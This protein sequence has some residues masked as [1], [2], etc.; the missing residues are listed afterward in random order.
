MFARQADSISKIFP[1]LPTFW[2]ISASIAHT[3][4]S[5]PLQLFHQSSV[6]SF[7]NDL[8][9]K[10]AK[11][12]HPMNFSLSAFARVALVRYW[13]L[14]GDYKSALTLAMSPVPSTEQSLLELF[15]SQKLSSSDSVS[16]ANVHA[17]LCYHAGFSALM[18][19]QFSDA[20]RL[21]SYP[22]SQRARRQSSRSLD[23][24]LSLCT[25]VAS[26]ASAALSLL[27]DSDLRLD[28]AINDAIKADYSAEYERMCKGSV[29]ACLS[30]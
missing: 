14:I 15:G 2:S 18:L 30:Q 21:C 16:L 26:I 20:A 27:S 24:L 4:C 17:S 1:T 13:T 6:Q 3:H 23:R 7:L 25:G 19:R 11:H 10:H 8:I 9:N 28:S 29:F 22:L 12:P 5:L